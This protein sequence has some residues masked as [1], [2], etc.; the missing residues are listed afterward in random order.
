VE[1]GKQPPPPPP[2]ERGGEQS[3]PVRRATGVLSEGKRG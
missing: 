3:I 2:A 1:A